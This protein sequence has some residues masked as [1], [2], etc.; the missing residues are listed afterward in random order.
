ME[1]MTEKEVR[2]LMISIGEAI[3]RCEEEDRMSKARDP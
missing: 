3:I 1:E 2:D